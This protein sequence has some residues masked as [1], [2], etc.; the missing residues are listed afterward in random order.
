MHTVITEFY[1]HI[2][3][4][5]KGKENLIVEKNREKAEQNICDIISKINSEA[6]A[7]YCN[8]DHLHVLLKYDPIYS[9]DHTLEEIKSKSSAWINKQGWM[10]KPFKWQSGF[11]SFTISPINVERET[12][13]ILN[14]PSY[15]REVSFREEYIGILDRIEME[16]E[17]HDL[18]EWVGQ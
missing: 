2:I 17:E 5:V 15:H 3:I 10:Q 4:A 8:P 16:Y 11:C 6:L 7:I 18:F 9:L 1:L 13:Y 14:Q 12:K